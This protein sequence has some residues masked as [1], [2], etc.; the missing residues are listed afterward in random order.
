MTYE[1]KLEALNA[2]ADCSLI[3]RRPGNWYVCQST[4]IKNGSVLEGRYG[5]GETPFA[6]I[7]DH[8][9]KLTSL[10]GHEYVVFRHGGVREAVRWNGFMWAHVNEEQ[11]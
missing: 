9:N 10:A 2:V 11:P 6:A 5:N 1:E 8:W 4:E 3:M 7:E